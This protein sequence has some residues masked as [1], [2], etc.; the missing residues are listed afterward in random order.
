[1][2][3]RVYPQKIGVT[4]DVRSIRANDNFLDQIDWV[5]DLLEKKVSR[6][7][8]LYTHNRFVVDKKKV[9]KEMKNIFLGH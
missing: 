1:M 8:F 3:H 5:S 9:L 2:I 4:D 7:K 6:Y